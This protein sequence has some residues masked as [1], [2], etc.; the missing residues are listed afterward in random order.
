MS[1][2]NTVFVGSNIINTQFNG[3]DLRG[4]N[5]HGA[6][7]KGVTFN[8]ADLRSVNFNNLKI[9]E[10]FL[11]ATADFEGADLTGAS[12][13]GVDLSIL[14]L[15]KEQLASLSKTG[16]PTPISWRTPAEEKDRLVPDPLKKIFN[17]DRTLKN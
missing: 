10:S 9:E 11:G 8:G 2:I 12:F 13:D 17:N 4:S 5:F 3:S 16:Q 15:T 6:S 7:I 1:A 14:N